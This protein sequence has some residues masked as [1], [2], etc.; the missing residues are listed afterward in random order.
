MRD[1]P[2]VVVPPRRARATA[3]RDD[4]ARTIPALVEPAYTDGGS[5]WRKRRR[6]ASGCCGHGDVPAGSRFRVSRAS[7]RCHPFSPRRNARRRGRRTHTSRKRHAAH[8][9]HGASASSPAPTLAAPMAAAT[10]RRSSGAYTRYDAGT[11]PRTLATAEDAADAEVP[12]YCSGAATTCRWK[13]ATPRA[14]ASRGR[15]RRSPRSASCAVSAAASRRTYAATARRRC[16][17]ALR[18]G[19]LPPAVR[20]DGGEDAVRAAAEAFLFLYVS[21][22]APRGRPPQRAV[23]DAS[24]PIGAGLGSSAAYSVALVAAMHGWRALRAATARRARRWTRASAW[25]NAW[26]FESERLLHGRPS[27]VDN[28][29]S[30]WRL[31]RVPGG[32]GGAARRDAGAAAAARQHA[33]RGTRRRAR[34]RRARAPRGAARRLRPHLWRRARARA[35]VRGALPLRRRRRRRRLRRAARRARRAL[36]STPCPRARRATP[37]SSASSTSRARPRAPRRGSPA[38]AAAAARWWLF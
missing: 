38:P 33:C 29:V 20:G 34:R 28:A 13:P 2:L 9:N 26:A 16:A 18:A 1:A 36:W 11:E 10:R 3:R 22:C 31:A 6:R 12:G 25:V 35:V 24:L 17:E 21:L 8:L 37:P 30:V 32:R 23:A 7:P 4:A 5:P 27:G 14:R 19:L 15:A